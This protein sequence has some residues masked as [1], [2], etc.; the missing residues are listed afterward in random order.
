MSL[1]T[2]VV[3]ALIPAPLAI[4]LTKDKEQP[5]SQALNNRN[6]SWSS[7]NKPSELS[8]GLGGNCYGK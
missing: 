4:M 7:N 3:R 6:V 8:R 1:V 5:S 2:M